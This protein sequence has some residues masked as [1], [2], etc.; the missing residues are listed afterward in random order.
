MQHQ[1][2]G[3]SLCAKISLIAIILCLSTFS[4]CSP[5]PVADEAQGDSFEQLSAIHE[6]YLEFYRTNK[7]APQ[8]KDDLA[9]LLK[10]SGHDSSG[11]FV[12]NRNNEEFVIVWDTN[13]ISKDPNPMVIG[14]ESSA[15]DD[16]RMVLTTMGVMT[17]DESEFQSANFPSG[18]TP[19]IP[20]D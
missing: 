16:Q 13:P 8:S 3:V 19:A 20:T 5:G 11:V 15:T 17:F 2:S 4:G 9:P 14:Y 1:L 6:S 10:K 7:K 18:H 12:S